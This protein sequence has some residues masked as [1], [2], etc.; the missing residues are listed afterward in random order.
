[1]V[2]PNGQLFY[3]PNFASSQYS[4]EVAWVAH[5]S[6]DSLFRDDKHGEI[7]P[8][9]SI[10]S[11]DYKIRSLVEEIERILGLHRLGEADE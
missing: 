7:V 4:Y 5:D 9:T 8:H 3:D 6:R 1:M 11:S 10:F 2:R